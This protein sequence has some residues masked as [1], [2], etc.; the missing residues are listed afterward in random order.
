MKCGLFVDFPFDASHNLPLLHFLPTA[1]IRGLAA[2]GANVTLV[3]T[4]THNIKQSSR[5]N[6]LPIRVLTPAVGSQQLGFASILGSFDSM[7]DTLSNEGERLNNLYYSSGEE[8]S[9]DEEDFEDDRN[10]NSDLFRNVG[11]NSVIELLRTR[12]KCETYVSTLTQSQRDVCDEGALFGPAKAKEHE[13]KILNMVKNN[14]NS[15]SKNNDDAISYIVPPKGYASN[16]L[17]RMFQYGITYSG[18][19]GKTGDMMLRGWSLRDFLELASWPRDSAGGASVRFGFPV[20]DDLEIENLYN[21]LEEDRDNKIRDSFGRKSGGVEREDLDEKQNQDNPF[22]IQVRGLKGLQNMFIS[23]EKDCLLFLL[24]P[25]CRT[26]NKILPQYTRMARLFSDS[27]P[28]LTFAKADTTGLIGKELG[29]ALQV[30]S[31]PAF[32]MFRQGRMYGSPIQVSKLPHKKL[33]MALDYLTSGNEWD[34]NIIRDE[35]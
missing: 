34:A 15:N 23:S 9:D 4:M 17:Q 12:H 25:F 20:I 35:N 27:H 11:S 13:N 26:C 1:N 29:K 10:S 14:N 16:T 33:E 32:V 24:A 22:V 3:S 19:D 6:E 7:L 8:I 2:L 21:K 31:V 28:S 18:A 30:V 5:E